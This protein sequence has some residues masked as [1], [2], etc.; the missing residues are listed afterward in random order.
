MTPLTLGKYVYPMWGQVIGWLMALSSMVLIPGYVIYMFCTTKGSIKQVRA[1]SAVCFFP[2]YRWRFA[3]ALFCSYLLWSQRQWLKYCFEFFVSQSDL[4][5]HAIV[6]RKCCY[7]NLITCYVIWVHAFTPNIACLPNFTFSIFLP[8][9]S[10]SSPGV[11]WV[12]VR[13]WSAALCLL[14]PALAEDDN[15]PGGWKAIGPWR[16]STHGKRGRSSCLARIV[17]VEIIRLPR[18]PCPS[19]H[20]LAARLCCNWNGNCAQYFVFCRWFTPYE[21]NQLMDGGQENNLEF[22]MKIKVDV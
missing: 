14:C 9:F 12:N 7:I 1:P 17:H 4:L 18:R 3:I 15:C 2:F 5:L 10:L 19:P 8:F 20:L 16:I 22:M 13:V 11:S 6:T 21:N